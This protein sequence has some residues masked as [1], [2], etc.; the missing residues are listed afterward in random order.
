M[1]DSTTRREKIKR[2]AGRSDTPIQQNS[3]KGKGWPL[4]IRSSQRNPRHPHKPHSR[5][6]YKQHERNRRQMSHSTPQ[7]ASRRDDRER[8]TR[9]SLRRARLQSPASRG[10]KRFRVSPARRATRVAP[11]TAAVP[12]RLEER[13]QPGI[14][15]EDHRPCPGTA[16]GRWWH[17]PW[18]SPDFLRPFSQ[19]RW[20]TPPFSGCAKW[21]RARQR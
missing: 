20:P 6:R 16:F 5:K 21:E 9:R 8:R 7:T 13:I 2:P 1:S 19:P 11:R 4:S 14:G 15:A 10:A 12:A 18:A 3:G 17:W